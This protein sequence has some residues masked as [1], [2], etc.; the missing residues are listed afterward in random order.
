MFGDMGNTCLSCGHAMGGV[1][2]G[3]EWSSATLVTE[4]D[5]ERA[6]DHERRFGVVH[7]DYPTQVH[8]IKD[9]GRRQQAFLRERRALDA[10]RQGRIPLHAM[11][12]TIKGD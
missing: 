10:R 11:C 2:L 4:V 6:F 12:D 7:V 9:S 8:T 1:L 3:S 5:L